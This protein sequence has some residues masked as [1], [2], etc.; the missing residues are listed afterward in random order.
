MAEFL[1]EEGS[2]GVID[3]G[4][5]AIEVLLLDGGGSLFGPAVELK[6]KVLGMGDVGVCLIDFVH[7]FIIKINKVNELSNNFKNSQK[8][9]EKGIISAASG[10]VT[11]SFD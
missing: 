10:Q 6:R 8:N 11:L 2:A 7:K 9:K 5:V 1:D 3:V 4:P